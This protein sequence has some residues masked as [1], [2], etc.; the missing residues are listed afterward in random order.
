MYTERNFY[1]IDLVT[2]YEYRIREAIDLGYITMPDGTHLDLTK[3]SSI[4]YLG[5]IIQ[6]NS[7]S[8]NRRFFG[9]F[10]WLS[11]LLLSGKTFD[12]Q[13]YNYDVKFLPSVLEHFET[14][15][16]DPIFWQLYKRVI[17]FY[18]QFNDQLPYY[19][20]SEIMFDGVKIT[21]VDIGKLVTYFDK[22]DSDITNA[23]NVEYL[24]LKN[25]KVSDLYKFGKVSHYNGEDFVVKARQWRLNHLPFTF[26][27]NVYSDRAVKSVV[28]VFLGPKYDEFNRVFDINVNREN[29]VLLDLFTYDLT[30]GNNVITRDSTEFTWFSKDYTTYF[31]LYKTT[32]LATAEKTKWDITDT[33][34]GRYGFPDRLMLPKGKKGGMPFQF[35]FIVS[36]YIAPTDEYYIDNL[37]MGYPFDRKIDE[38]VWYTPNMYYYDVNI[39]HKKEIDVNTV[40]TTNYWWDSVNGTFI[41]AG[42]PQCE[43]QRTCCF[44]NLI[45]KLVCS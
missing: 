38:T 37:P 41:Y 4:E 39:F 28:R 16:R 27:L 11:K 34:E 33:T 26:N 14:T 13:T 1:E 45:E 44:F 24:G 42:N 36:P 30:V 15:L 22:F 6:Y 31:D 7:D 19:K 18:W 43:I 25:E 2:D 20:K 17:N 8:P 23:V 9:Y 5:N 10:I 12:I 29:W 40:H 21:S 35:Y 32:M 3:P